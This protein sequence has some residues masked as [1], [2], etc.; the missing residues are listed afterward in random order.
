M[1]CFQVDGQDNNA[2]SIQVGSLAQ[3]TREAGFVVVNAASGELVVQFDGRS[4]LLVGLSPD[5]PQSVCG[6]CGNH[7]DNPA[8]DKVLPD[9][10]LA[11][12]DRQFGQS[13]KSDASRPG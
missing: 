8:D 4:T 7:N 1:F 9:G 11:Q 13:W 2:N 5:Y 10:T 12:T 3:V 6:M